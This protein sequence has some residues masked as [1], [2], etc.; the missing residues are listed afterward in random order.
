MHSVRA[1]STEGGLKLPGQDRNQFRITVVGSGDGKT[2]E[3]LLYSMSDLLLDLM[4]KASRA[5][6][7]GRDCDT[8]GQSSGAT[9]SGVID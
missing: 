2:F 6:E 8:L 5:Y 4:A 9:N 7:G 1:P 3:E